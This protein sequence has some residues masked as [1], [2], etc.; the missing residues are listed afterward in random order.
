MRLGEACG[1]RIGD[2]DF[3]HEGVIR[4][5]HSYGGPLKERAIVSEPSP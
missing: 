3:L 5:A 4:V 2:L 1:L